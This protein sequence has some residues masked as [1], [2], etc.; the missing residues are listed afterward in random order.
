M[1]KK[2]SSKEEEILTVLLK[3]S[4]FKELIDETQSP[5]MDIG[6]YLLNIES[7]GFTIFVV[8]LPKRKRG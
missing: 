4:T 3:G 8:A 7:K 2:L 5:A 6:Q 1:T